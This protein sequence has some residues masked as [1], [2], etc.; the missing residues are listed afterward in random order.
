MKKIQAIVPVNFFKV[1]APIFTIESREV[2]S[3]TKLQEF[4]TKVYLTKN[5]TENPDNSKE[6]IV[7]ARHSSG[8]QLIQAFGKK[9]YV[10]SDDDSFF[11]DDQHALEVVRG[12]VREQRN[13]AK[14]AFEAL[15]NLDELYSNMTSIA[16]ESAKNRETII[17]EENAPQERS[18]EKHIYLE[19]D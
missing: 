2:V 11:L 6:I 15:S 19:Q 7:I 14:E 13:K 18:S 12:K 9:S 5:I 10:P 3:G 17:I 16:P 8:E 1:D 4:S